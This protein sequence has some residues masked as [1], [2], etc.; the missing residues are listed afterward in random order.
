MGVSGCGKTTVGAL[1]AAGLGWIFLD[2]DQLHPAANIA[3]MRRGEPLDE[4]DRAPWLQAVAATITGWQ[5][6]GRHGVLACSALRRSHRATI[7]AV[8]GMVRFVYLKGSPTL[9]AARLAGRTGHF[10]P[11]ALLASQFATLEEPSADER[12][13]TVDIDAPAASL[14][15]RILASLA[16]PSA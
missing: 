13:I 15:E 12:A 4:A 2:A 7:A 9:I 8:P 14:V 1:L 5:E 6:A 11:P 3:K 16:A 10:M